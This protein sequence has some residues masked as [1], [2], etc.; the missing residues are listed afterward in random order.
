MFL[1][2]K[3]DPFQMFKWFLARVEK[4]TGKILKFLRY[5]I[6]S[7]FISKEVNI[8]YNDRV[9]KR[10]IFVSRTPPQNCMAKRRNRSIMDYAR[11]LMMEKNV[12]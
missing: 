6:E 12:A 5:D 3:S 1:K 9:I 11:T 7:E 8:F 10:Q 2:E 4:E